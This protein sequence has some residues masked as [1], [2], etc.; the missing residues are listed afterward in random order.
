MEI[1]RDTGESLCPI[2]GLIG[3]PLFSFQMMV[4]TVVN[5]ADDEAEESADEKADRVFEGAVIPDI[6]HN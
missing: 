5:K 6:E 2:L 4:D 1:K 3:N